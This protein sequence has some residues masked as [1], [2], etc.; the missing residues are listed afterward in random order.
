M[1]HGLFRRRTNGTRRPTISRPLQGGDSDGYWTIQCGLTALLISDQ[2]PGA[3]PDNTR[4]GNF[5]RDDGIANGYNDGYAVTGS[6]N[7]SISQNYL[8]DVGAYTSSPSYY[9]TFD[10]GGNLY[11]WNEAQINGR[12]RGSRGGSWEVIIFDVNELSAGNRSNVPPPTSEV[13]YL[14]FRVATIFVP[15]PA[16]VVLLLA[17]LVGFIS[18]HCRR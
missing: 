16:S 5:Y 17:G 2:P 11:E 12:A 8:T 13:E 15:E 14:G 9:G 6:P 10:Q 3:T 7:Y 4:V 18:K 1:P